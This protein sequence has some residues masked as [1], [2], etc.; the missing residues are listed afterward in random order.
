[1]ELASPSG[2]GWLKPSEP[3]YPEESLEAQAFPAEG[4]ANH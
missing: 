1:M 2:L 3:G 4:T